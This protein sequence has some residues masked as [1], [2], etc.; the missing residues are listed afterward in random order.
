MNKTLF[1]PGIRWVQ[2]IKAPKEAATEPVVGRHARGEIS[3]SIKAF[4]KREAACFSS[5]TPAAAGYCEPTPLSRAFFSASIPI[6][7]AGRPG[8]PWSIRIK[9][10]PVSPSRREATSNT[11]PMVALAKSATFI[12]FATE[13][14]SSSLNT[15]LI[16]SQNFNCLTYS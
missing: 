1:F 13:F 3:I 7:L 16:G 8:D 9:G 11:S 2:A 15:R 14:T 12:S 4:T 5:A 10:I 6:L